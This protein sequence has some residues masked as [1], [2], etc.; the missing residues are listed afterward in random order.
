M[1]VNGIEVIDLYG[2]SLT[3]HPQNSVQ[4]NVHYTETGYALLADLIVKEIN[5]VLKK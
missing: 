1:K 3:I 2:A 5:K 4:G